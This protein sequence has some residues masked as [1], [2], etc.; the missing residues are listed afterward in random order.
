MKIHP[1][2]SVNIKIGDKFKYDLVI[3]VI[4][5]IDK[6]YHYYFVNC[7]DTITEYDYDKDNFIKR[8]ID[9]DYIKI[10]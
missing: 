9:G 1:N 4:T 2:V 6:Y 10:K 7:S 5:R 3:F 8:I